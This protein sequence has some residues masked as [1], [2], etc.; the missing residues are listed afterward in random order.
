MTT[1]Q[2]G[3]LLPLPSLAR[4]LVFQLLPGAAPASVLARLADTR[5]G[6][7]GVV[8]IG[9]STAARLGTS[10]PGLHEPSVISGPG[11]SLPVTPAALWCWYRGRP[12][13]TRSG[14]LDLSRLG[15]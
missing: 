1:F 11:G 10:I 4:H 8:G 12:V 7:D 14:Q 15:I 9:P 3:I 5:L 13:P 6:N 2:P